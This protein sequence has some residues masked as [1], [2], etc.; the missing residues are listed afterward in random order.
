MLKQYANAKSLQKFMQTFGTFLFY[1]FAAFAWISFYFT[2]VG[3][4]MH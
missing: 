2:C 4:I 3:S 1:F